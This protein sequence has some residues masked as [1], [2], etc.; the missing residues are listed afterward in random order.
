MSP[1][2]PNY[3]F[4]ALKILRLFLDA[5]TTKLTGADLM[6]STGLASGNLYPLLRQLEGRGILKSRWEDGDPS[7]LGRPLRRFYRIT[8]QG[9]KEGRRVLGELGVKF[10]AEEK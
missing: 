7:H 9:E 8:K 3:T 6:D 2:E 1:R 10:E 5:P 4:K